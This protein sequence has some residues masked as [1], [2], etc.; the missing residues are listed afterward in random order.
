[1]V[2]RIKCSRHAL[3]DPCVAEACARACRRP[4]QPAYPETGSCQHPERSSQPNPAPQLLAH[5]DGHVSDDGKGECLHIGCGAIEAARVK[6]EH[7][8]QGGQEKVTSGHAPGAAAKGQQQGS[9]AVQ[10]SSARFAQLA[11]TRLPSRLTD[12]HPILQAEALRQC[13]WDHILRNTRKALQLTARSG[14]TKWRRR[15]RQ[16]GRPPL[17]RP[18]WCQS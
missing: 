15:R 18:G 3:D 1:M 8:G 4:P 6:P 5:T 2:Q 16:T 17:W 12:A 14:T 13:S 9:G 11:A 10:R 7:M